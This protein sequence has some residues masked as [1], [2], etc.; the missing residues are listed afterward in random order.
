MCGMGF[1]R[2]MVW[3]HDGAAAVLRCGTNSFLRW[4][5]GSGV[6]VN[7]DSLQVEIWSSRM[8]GMRKGNTLM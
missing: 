1:V 2:P 4:K 7:G 3:R 5:N 6:G 8:I